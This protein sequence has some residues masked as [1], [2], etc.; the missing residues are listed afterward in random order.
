MSKVQNISDVHK[1]F[2]EYY[3]IKVKKFS[4]K[5]QEEFDEWVYML[6]HSQV[7][8]EFKS[9]NIQVAS[10]KLRVMNMDTKNRKSYDAYMDGLSYEA[11]MIWSAK[12]DG[13]E[14][15]RKLLEQEKQRAEQEKQ[16]AEKEKQR[17]EQEKQRAQKE[18]REKE[19]AIKRAEK[20]AEQ[21]RALG[22]KPA[23]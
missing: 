18:K 1:I 13:R 12:E 19:E 6:K 14:E 22:T 11:S 10:E 17:A 7:K 8:P 21:L 2:P 23:D 16:R 15:G 9:K 4:D 20:L 3:L 5:I